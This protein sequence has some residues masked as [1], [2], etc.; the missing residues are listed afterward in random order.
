MFG[1]CVA[2]RGSVADISVRERVAGRIGY[3]GRVV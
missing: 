1:N 2:M 3:R